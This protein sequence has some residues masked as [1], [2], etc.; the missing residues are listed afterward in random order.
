M[1]NDEYQHQDFWTKVNEKLN[2]ELELE[3]SKKTWIQE[4]EEKFLEQLKEDIKILTK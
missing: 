2:Q 4:Q 1:S 3:V